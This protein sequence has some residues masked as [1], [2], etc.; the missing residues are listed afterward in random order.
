[1]QDWV[2][3]LG[4]NLILGSRDLRAILENFTYF[5]EVGRYVDCYLKK[6]YFKALKNEI[7]HCPDYL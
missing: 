1:M 2:F 7:I 6:R 3:R 5:L 4:I